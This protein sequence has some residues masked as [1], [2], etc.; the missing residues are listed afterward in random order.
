MTLCFL[1]RTTRRMKLSSAEVGKMA[2]GTG[3][4]LNLSIRIHMGMWRRQ[5]EMVKDVWSRDV[6][7]LIV[8]NI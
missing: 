6:I 8:L 4:L 5:L 1:A 3:L 2:G 7:N